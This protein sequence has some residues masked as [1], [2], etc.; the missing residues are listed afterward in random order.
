M[1][2]KNKEDKRKKRR[3][4]YQK[5]KEKCREYNKEYYQK[6]KKRIN[7]QGRQWYQKN[8][9]R[10]LQQYLKHKKRKNRRSV[11][12]QRE[13]RKIDIRFRL[14]KDLGA[15]IRQALNRN[16]AGRKW[17]SLV[18]YT[19]EDLMERLEFNFDEN[20]NWNNYGSYWSID[21][22]KPKSLFGY[23]TPKDQAFKDCWSLA[24]LQPME[25]ME[26]IRKSNHF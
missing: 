25:K 10:I 5:N 4:Y 8:R 1:P 2:Y 11:I 17:E 14:D 21:H 23:K 20:M 26:N 22:R 12:Y 9:E 3:E 13:R 24:N 7:R 19:L 16:K 18:G 15:Q 6:N